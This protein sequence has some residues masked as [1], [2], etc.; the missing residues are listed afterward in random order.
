MINNFK[1]KICC[2][3]NR[4]LVK[5][6]WRRARTYS[7]ILLPLFL[8]KPRRRK[9]DLVDASVLKPRRNIGRREMRKSWILRSV[10]L[11]TLLCQIERPTVLLEPLPQYGGYWTRLVLYPSNLW[12]PNTWRCSVL[13]FFAFYTLPPE[14][15]AI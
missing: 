10:G 2:I 6:K 14:K 5:C 1:I 11:M 13:S 3:L 4:S 7:C 15:E 12:I 8:I 9:G